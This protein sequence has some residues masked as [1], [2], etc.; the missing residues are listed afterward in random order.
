MKRTWILGIAELPQGKESSKPLFDEHF[1]HVPRPS[2]TWRKRHI[3]VSVCF[4]TFTL[5][6]LPSVPSV[7]AFALVS[8]P[9][10]HVVGFFSPAGRLKNKSNRSSWAKLANVAKAQKFIAHHFAPLG[11]GL[12]SQVAPKVALRI[13]PFNPR[14]RFNRWFPKMGAPPVINPL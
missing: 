11:S 8:D 12:G 3:I 6:L 9:V 13:Q 14:G 4:S 7:C 5:L 1:F 10:T 2:W